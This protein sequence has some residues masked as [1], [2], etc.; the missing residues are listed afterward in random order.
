MESKERKLAVAIARCDNLSIA[1]RDANHPCHKV[2]NFQDDSPRRHIPE[3]WF[4]NISNSKVLLIASNPS[5]DMNED[6]K[7]E[8]YPRSNWTNDE[9]SEWVT[10]R[11]DQS[12]DEVPVTFQ[13][14]PFKDF[15]WRCIDGEY[16]GAGKGTQ[17]QP[18]WNNAHRLVIEL[19]G[20]GANP[21]KNYALTEVV[22]CKSQNA[23]GVPEASAIC[24]ENW[25]GKIMDLAKDANVVVLLGSHV[26]P[27]AQK[28]FRDSV[29]KDFGERVS[30]GGLEV[31]TRDSFVLNGRVYIYLPHPTAAEPGGRLP[32]TR[33][34]TQSHRILSE[35]AKG[36][37][38]VPETTDELHRLFRT[39]N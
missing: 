27:W 28:Q 12:W 36:E 32:S 13:R 18:T 37:R 38:K 15:L 1:V 22:H 19:L 20:K 14:S 35:I 11:V 21:S 4:G 23:I 7:G 9:I 16:R 2:V 17:P 6:K 24:S 5:I 3:A 34:G 10:R 33:F 31:A 25:L 26:R 8:N 30:D 39:I 29:P